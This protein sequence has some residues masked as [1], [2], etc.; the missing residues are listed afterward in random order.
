VALEPAVQTRRPV[1]KKK[2]RKVIV[3][4]EGSKG[5]AKAAVGKKEG[6][7]KGT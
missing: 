6:N 3:V 5:G 7:T 1:A 2:T 4:K